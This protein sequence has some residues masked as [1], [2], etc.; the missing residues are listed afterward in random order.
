MEF[1]K[2][3]F[4]NFGFP[5]SMMCLSYFC[6]SL[7]KSFAQY[8]CFSYT[9][10]SNSVSNHI[11]SYLDIFSDGSEILLWDR[12]ASVFEHLHDEFC[13]ISSC[14]RNMLDATSDDETVRLFKKRRLQKYR[15]NSF[16][17]GITWVTPC[18]LSQTVPVNP[19]FFCI[20]S[21]GATSQLE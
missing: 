9:N 3:C 1:I 15:V 17:T 5:P 14:E 12:L 13:H 6:I 8:E 18:P 21:D 10:S 7:S 11:Y 20:E 19:I 16:T 4:L 2:E